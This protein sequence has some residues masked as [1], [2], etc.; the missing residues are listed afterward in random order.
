LHKGKEKEKERER[1]REREI[2]ADRKGERYYNY[3]RQ[4][5]R[6]ETDIIV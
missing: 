3:Y 2:M 1:G 4:K 5:E 6:K